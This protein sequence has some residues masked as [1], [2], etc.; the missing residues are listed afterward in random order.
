MDM[1]GFGKQIWR[2]VLEVN[3]IQKKVVLL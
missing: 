2:I 1:A 3:I